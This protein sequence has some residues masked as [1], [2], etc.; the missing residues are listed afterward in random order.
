MLDDPFHEEHSHE[1]RF[2]IPLEELVEAELI[3]DDF[4]EDAVPEDREFVGEDRLDWDSVLE[5]IDVEVRDDANEVALDEANT[6]EDNLDGSVESGLVEKFDGVKTE[7]LPPV[8]LGDL[9]VERRDDV[10][11]YLS[12]SEEAYDN[13]VTLYDNNYDQVLEDAKKQ[14]EV[15]KAYVKPRPGRAW[16]KSKVSPGPRRY[17]SPIQRQETVMNKG[18]AGGPKSY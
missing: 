10:P 3:Q 14:E 16:R 6:T 4:V 12:G 2:D 7:D 1:D 15:E 18:Y 17:R 13:Q 9:A 8:E 11:D 5:N